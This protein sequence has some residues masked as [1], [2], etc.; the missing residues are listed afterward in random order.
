METLSTTHSQEIS[1]FSSQQHNLLDR[2]SYS[3]EVSRTIEDLD[4]V[5]RKKVSKGPKRICENSQFK[6]STCKESLFSSSPLCFTP[7]KQGGLRDVTNKDNATT[8]K[9]GLSQQLETIFPPTVNKNKHAAKNNEGAQYIF[10]KGSQK[11]TKTG[12]LGKRNF[13]EYDDREKE[14]QAKQEDIGITKL[15]EEEKKEIVQEV[16][17]IKENPPAVKKSVEQIY[18]FNHTRNEMSAF[19]VY[20]DKDLG[21]GVFVQET[22]KETEV[23]NDCQTDTEVMHT[24][25]KWTMDDLAEG[26]QRHFAEKANELEELKLK[27]QREKEEKEKMEKENEAEEKFKRMLEGFTG[28]DSDDESDEL[29]GGYMS[30]KFAED[31]KENSKKMSD[32]PGFLKKILEDL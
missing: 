19:P 9:K 8:L 3:T 22:L 15:P 14:S 11:I 25:Q 30:L 10:G 32:K 17:R 5:I 31:S 23:D 1:R 24:V 27:S 16:K 26:I 13:F 28:F 2:T 20:Q 29:F 6:S 21:Y 4:P 18:Y 12:W 7:I